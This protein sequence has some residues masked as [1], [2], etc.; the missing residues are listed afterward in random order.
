MTLLI[1]LSG[2]S[3]ETFIGKNPSLDFAVNDMN[4]A[5]YARSSVVCFDQNFTPIY[6]EIKIND[7]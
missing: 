3:S 1:L 4:N 5:K 7:C 6:L 2:S